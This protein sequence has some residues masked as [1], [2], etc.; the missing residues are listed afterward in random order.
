M[1]FSRIPVFLIIFFIMFYAYMYGEKERDMV[2]F[3][4]IKNAAIL[5]VISVD[6]ILS[7]T[8]MYVYMYVC[9]YVI[10]QASKQVS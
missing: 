8:Y 1:G 2:L 5:S 4:F 10:M 7:Y 3:F 9:N 6:G